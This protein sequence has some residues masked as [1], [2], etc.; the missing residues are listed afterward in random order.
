M[1][2]NTNI[3][4]PHASREAAKY[5][6]PIPSREYILEH[7]ETRGEPGDFSVLCSELKLE[8]PEDCDALSKRLNA[9]CR[10]GQLI[11]SR[12]GSYG[13]VNKMDLV[14]G[15][16]MGHRDGF[17]FLI[18]EDGSSD[19]YLGPRQ[20]Q[21]VFDGDIILA[22]VSGIDR[23]GRKEGKVAEILSRKSSRIVGRFYKEAGAGV[24][25]PHNK[26]IS[27]EV[28]ISKK[29]RKDAKDGDF[30]MVEITRFPEGHRK[31][32]G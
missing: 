19:L 17:G 27:Q 18:P 29:H 2:K 21:K 25:V 23:R 8:S 13:L 22:R 31:A 1:S 24:V 11:C 16:V 32:S 7:L 28:L 12:S 9:M 15:R 26:R 30:V 20:M 6:N 5:D 3:D 4:D 14:K 10:A